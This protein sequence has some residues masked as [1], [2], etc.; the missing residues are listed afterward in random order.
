MKAISKENI[1]VYYLPRITSTTPNSVF[2]IMVYRNVLS[3]KMTDLSLSEKE[4]QNNVDEMFMENGWK[5]LDTFASTTVTHYHPN[6]HEAYGVIR[7]SS[8]LILGLD[9]NVTPAE[10]SEE[11]FDSLTDCIKVTLNL[12][13]AIVIPAGVSHCSKVNSK[14]YRYV[15]AYP[16]E[17]GRYISV[18]KLYIKNRSTDGVYDNHDDIEM[19]IKATFPQGD[20]VYGKESG[21]LTDLWT[22]QLQ[23]A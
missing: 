17:G 3:S 19:T 20:P 18:N 10:L 15:A 4:R 22:K 12:G 9:V 23:V 16:F 8:T 1:E 21:T 11:D 5:I 6:V 2:P 7:G 13:D 14:D